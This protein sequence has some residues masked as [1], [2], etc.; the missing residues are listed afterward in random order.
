[1]NWHAS[2]PQ[3]SEAQQA[4]LRKHIVEMLVPYYANVGIPSVRE[5]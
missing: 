3:T 5:D 4:E 1:M 2:L